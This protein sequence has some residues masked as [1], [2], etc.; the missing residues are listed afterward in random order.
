MRINSAPGSFLIRES[1]TR[2]GN[3]V[4][5]CIRPDQMIMHYP[6]VLCCMILLTLYYRITFVCGHLF[7][8]GQQ[9][10]SLSSLVAYHVNDV[11]RKSNIQH[12]IAPPVASV[13]ADAIISLF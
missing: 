13:V 6:Y 10:D 12:P 1:D 3:Y 9:F 11:E 4:L 5:S 2:P 8:A 7:M